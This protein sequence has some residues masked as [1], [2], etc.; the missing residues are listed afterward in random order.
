VPAGQLLAAGGLV[1]LA[2]ARRAPRREGVARCVGTW[3]LGI[4]NF[5]INVCA[6][7]GARSF[8]SVLSKKQNTSRG[9]FVGGLFGEIF[10]ASAG[11]VPFCQALMRFAHRSSD[12]SE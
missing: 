2:A 8:T 1:A 10:S 3:R 9:D 5:S 4:P 12:L 6:S 11:S 7:K